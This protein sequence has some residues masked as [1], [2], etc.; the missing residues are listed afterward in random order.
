MSPNRTQTCKLM[1]ACVALSLLL[2]CAPRLIRGKPPLVS[3]QSLQT[4][5]SQ[6][7]LGLL[8]RNANEVPLDLTSMQFTLTLEEVEL[9]RY[10]DQFM[11]SISASGAENS[12]FSLS[13]DPVGAERLKA[14][15]RG[16][17]TSLA[18]TIE[19]DAVS[20]EDGALKFNAEGRLYPVPGRSGQFR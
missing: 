7:E 3:I 17:I 16:D 4:I 12:L 10:S 15:E 14:L 20:A 8:L 2:A 5:E 6:I 1:V 19:G 18:Y 13:M 11:L 9:A